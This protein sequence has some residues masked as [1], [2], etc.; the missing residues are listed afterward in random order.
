MQ[1]VYF[2]LQVEQ[3]PRQLRKAGADLAVKVSAYFPSNELKFFIR[4]HHNAS[5]F[6]LHFFSPISRHI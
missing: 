5:E 6:T 4:L 2:V 3:N 1:G